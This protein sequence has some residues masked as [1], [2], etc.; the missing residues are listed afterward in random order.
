[1]LDLGELDRWAGQLERTADDLRLAERRLDGAL[2]GTAWSS[3]AAARFG[4]EAQEHAR[5]MR[6]VADELDQAASALRRHRATADARQQ[7]LGAALDAVLLAGRAAVSGG[8]REVGEAMS[9]ARQ[10][11]ED[12][13]RAVAEAAED[14]ARAAADAAGDTF[15]FLTG[16]MR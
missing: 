9:A 4:Q 7:Q 15:R 6:S 13:A 10:Q 12:A 16:P 5:R 14:A 11:F 8:V 1:M 3:S 2:A